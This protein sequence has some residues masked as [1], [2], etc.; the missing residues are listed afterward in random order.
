MG[1]GASESVA[2]NMN[3][4]IERVNAGEIVISERNIENTTPTTI[5]EFA[6]TFSYAYNM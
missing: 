6:Q 3:E 4:F 2:D 1:I 5:E